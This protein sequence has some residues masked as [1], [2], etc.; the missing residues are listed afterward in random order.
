V[1]AV[2]LEEGEERSL[3]A[4]LRRMES[5]RQAVEGCALVR[6][7]LAGGG[8]DGGGV[9]DGILAVERALK[10][11]LLQEEAASMPGVLAT[12][13]AHDDN[14]RLFWCMVQRFVAMFINSAM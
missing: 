1:R 11:V 3:R 4:A 13:A 12:C 10:G 2:G 9:E 5:R 6:A 14:A 7:A 8:G